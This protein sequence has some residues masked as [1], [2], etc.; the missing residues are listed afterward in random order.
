[1]VVH[2]VAAVALLLLTGSLPVQ[3]GNGPSHSPIVPAQVDEES[4]AE[5]RSVFQRCQ[6]CHVVNDEQNRVGPH[7][8]GLFG[9]QSGSVEGFRYSD[10]MVEAGIVWDD[11][12]LAAYLADPRGYL[13]G[14]R[15]AFP[16]LADEEAL[17]ALLVYL[18]E[19]TAPPQEQAE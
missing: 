4:F 11:E 13:P 19:A 18:R 8:V 6:A 10:V 12:T 14:N 3:G 5:G 15:M 9:R 16:G 7:L 17:A 2:R 1:M